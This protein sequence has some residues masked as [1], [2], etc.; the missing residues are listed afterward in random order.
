[1]NPGPLA[2][3]A[4]QKPTMPLIHHILFVCSVTVYK[5]YGREMLYKGWH[6]SY[7]QT[8]DAPHSGFR[9]SVEVEALNFASLSNRPSRILL[10]CGVG[11]GMSECGI[12]ERTLVVLVVAIFTYNNIV[13]PVVRG[14][15]KC[16]TNMKCFCGNLRV[17]NVQVYVL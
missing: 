4:R 6:P 13:Q 2:Y 14:C 3:K 8:V 1:M 10:Y 9:Q 16:G 17:C 15:I 5:V 11:Y 7:T 12:A